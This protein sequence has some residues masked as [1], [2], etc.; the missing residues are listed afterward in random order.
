MKISCTQQGLAKGIAMVQRAVS[1]R[2]TLPVLGNI[3]LEAH[4]GQLRL[5]ASNLDI[6]SA[7]WIAAD[8]VEEGA[9][10]VPARLFGEMVTKLLPGRVDLALDAKTLSVHLTSGNFKAKVAG[11][12][13]ND[14]PQTQGDATGGIELD[15]RRLAEMIDQVAFAATTDLSRP[16][17]MCVQCRIGANLAMAA[18]D[19]FRLGVRSVPLDPGASDREVL[20]PATSI[21]ELGRI[22]ADADTEK[23][24]VM[25]GDARRAV[26]AVDGK[27]SVLRA[28]LSTQLV[29]GKYPD[30]RAVIPKH[31]TTNVV[32]NN[33][34]LLRS[35]QMAR[36]F[37]KGDQEV[38]TLT[39]NPNDCLKV[40]AIN[41]ANGQS[42]D[43]L[44]AE[45]KGEPVTIALNVSYLIALCSRLDD[46][47]LLIEMTT[48]NRP[49]SLR[50]A[51]SAPDEFI[52]VIMPINRK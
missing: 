7:C 50:P 32:V 21:N 37:A 18:T 27:G 1:P 17:L 10:T 9:I 34:A 39:A 20:I 19:G 42:D 29:D 22:L 16:N 48:A 12:D 11:I 40:S 6:T 38:V 23:P 44:E 45:I 4:G 46:A 52:H 14:F 8:I 25:S 2:S 47:D 30:Y 3:L 41:D 51:S 43:A 49:V 31:S 13:A 15:A 26:F 5:V 35:L 33:A 24:V 36:L 28:E